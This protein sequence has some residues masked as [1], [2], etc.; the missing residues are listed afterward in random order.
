MATSNPLN[1][2]QGGTDDQEAFIDPNEAAEEY[3]DE[4]GDELFARI[5]AK[6]VTAFEIGEVSQAETDDCSVESVVSK[7]QMLGIP[8]LPLNFAF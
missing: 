6:Q 5:G 4:L 8:L 1:D 7:G 3:A 2:E